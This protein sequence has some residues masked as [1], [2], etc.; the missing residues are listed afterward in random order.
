MDLLHALP[1]PTS[2]V[3]IAVLHQPSDAISSLWDVLARCCKLPVVV[4]AEFEDLVPGVC[5]I[6]EPDGHLSLL[7]GQGHTK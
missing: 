4:A 3:V 2:A 6:D 7:R 5:Y 1:Q